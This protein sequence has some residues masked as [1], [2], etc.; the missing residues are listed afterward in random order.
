ME[1]FKLFGTIAVDN[2]SAVKGMNNTADTAQKTGESMAQSTEKAEGRMSGAFSKIGQGAIAI[3]KVIASGVAVGTVAVAGLAK[4][5][6]DSYADYE[7][8][9]G[10]VETLF[11]DGA[12][13]VKQYASQAFSSAGLSANE[14]MET[15]TSFSASLIQSLN[16]DTV[17]ASEVANQAIIDM[18]D[19]ANK[20]GSSIE[21]IQNAYQG[22]AKQNYTMLDNL[23]LGYGGTK[24]EMARL[25]KDAS[26]MKK[27]QKELGI[28]VDESS[29]SFA[30]IVNAISV[31]QKSMG[32][33]NATADEAKFTISGS[34]SA[35][36]ASWKNLITGIADDNQD[37][38][39]LINNFVES[40]GTA[41]ENIMPRLEV[42]LNGIGKMVTKLAPIIAQ[43]LPQVLAD[44]LPSLIKGA[45]ALIK[46]FVSVLPQLLAVI[47][48]QIPFIVTEIGQA[49]IDVFPVLLETIQDLLGQMIDFIGEELFGVSDSSEQVFGYI[50]EKFNELWAFCSE[51]WATVGQ[52]IWDMFIDTV[53]W[54][55][56]NFSV[57][58]T[59]VSNAF[60]TLWGICG[61]WWNSSGKPIWDAIL[62]VFASLKANSDSIFPAI[63]TYFQL[64]CDGWNVAWTNI[65]QP[66]WDMI[67]FA[68]TSLADLFA[69]NMPAIMA[70]FD[71][72]IAGIK[73]TWEN[74]LKPCLDAIGVF[75]NE[76]LKPI[77][78]FV[79]KNFVEPLVVS[80]FKTIADLW[81]NFLKPVFDGICDFLTGVF[82]LNWEK[83]FEG[84]GGIVKGV[85]NG[86]I[87]VV[88]G[89]WNIIRTV[90]NGIIEGINS[91]GGFIGLNVAI[92][93][94]PESKIPTLAKGGILEKGQI[95]LLEGNGAE[96]VVPLDQNEKWINRVAQDM[97]S[98]VGSNEVLYKILDA[99]NALSES[100]PEEIAE[101]IASMRFEINNREFARLVK[102]V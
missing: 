39:A 20:M 11:K 33:A 72:A 76:V 68:I 8:L 63:Q 88:N 38:D 80:V 35:M 50:G 17:K 34:V 21:S 4:S 97:N 49:L 16:G 28:T 3:G 41:I 87:D 60:G 42:I 89:A 75:M 93:T 92:P 59:G 74:K 32:I 47:I 64:L 90:I 55:A 67:T 23:K 101:S 13:K 14:Y 57:I 77:F 79:W 6:L 40:A 58:T 26:K 73:D 84:L 10:G 48:E 36:K 30:N 83:A 61:E 54:V 70:F 69:E 51:V 65:G 12:S 81:T 22:F 78:E 7:Q 62:G 1:L 100:L 44:L 45:T 98:A 85:F 66:I 96:A 2:S 18:A 29:M 71:E 46:G 99:L 82:T 91:V 27:V 52:P 43:K 25:I 94:I 56:D 31:M 95:G 86:I 5:A 24:E 19:N 102:G 9:V 53:T 15:V 37:F